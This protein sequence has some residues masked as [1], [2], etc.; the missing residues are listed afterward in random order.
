[1]V[2][3]FTLAKDPALPE[4]NDDASVV[5]ESRLAIADGASSDAFSGI[6]AQKLCEQFVVSQALDRE[7]AA[8]IWQEAVRQHPLPWFLADKLRQPTHASF[9]GA[10]WDQELLQVQAVGDT[11]V[12]VIRDDTLVFA[13]PCDSAEH[14]S[15][16]P[17]LVPTRG[18]LPEVRHTSFPLQPS[19]LI[20][21]ATDALAAWLLREQDRQPWRSLLALQNES[22]FARWVQSLRAAGRLALDDTT[23]ILIG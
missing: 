15:T 19:D 5:G 3:V 21:F 1:M 22:D 8:L 17:A 2:K 14:F 16:L 23:A 12:F 10:E 11:C 4:Q 7:R 9:L 13:F 20:L 6:W 18:A